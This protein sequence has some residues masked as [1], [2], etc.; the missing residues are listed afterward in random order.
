MNSDKIILS[1]L[2]DNATIAV[3]QWGIPHIRANNKRDLF[4]A[5]GFNAARDRLW[6]I[7][8]WR[9]RG[10]G[11][12]AADFGPGYLEQDR[13]A[14]LFLYRGE[15]ESEW[16]AYCPDAKEIA[17]AF[18]S[19]INAYIEMIN[20]GK[21]AL[22]PE[23]TLFGTSPTRWDAED[24][25]RIRTH[26]MMRN[27]LS[28][29]I[30]ANVISRSS[31]DIDVLRQ[32]LSPPIHPFI[33]DGIA[34]DEIPLEVTDLFKL[35]LAAVTF[36]QDRLNA[37]LEDA[38]SWRTVAGT[39]D[40]VR[41]AFSQGSNNWVVHGS[42][43]ASGRPIL[44]NDP[45]RAH[46]VPSLR[47]LVHLSCPEFDV[48]GAGEPNLPGICIGHNGNSAFGLTLFYGHDQEDLYVYETSPENP[49]Y[50]RYDGG[51]EP[52]RIIEE[53][54]TLKDGTSTVLALRF[55]RHGAVVYEDAARHRAYVIK[56]VWSD[57]GTAPYF[58][59]LASMRTKTFPDFQNAMTQ[60]GVP[61][62][63]QVYADT[64]GTI[65]WVVAGFSPIRSNW[66]GLLPVPGDGR[67]EWK[68][69]FPADRLPTTINP[70]A[71]FFST[72]NENNLP[73]NWN[74]E[75]DQIGYEW[76][77]RSR[78]DRIQEIL[79]ENKLQTIQSSGALQMDSTS[80]VA[81]RLTKIIM[82]LEFPV[83]SVLEAKE[84]FGEWN[85]R[86]DADSSAA[87]LFE[88][89]WSKH[90]RPAL[91]KLLTND[92]VVQD[93]LLPGDP[94]TIVKLLEMPDSRLGENPEAA[95]NDVLARSL[96]AALTECRERLG[97]DRHNWRWGSLHKVH[98]VHATSNIAEDSGNDLSPIEMAGSDSSP[99]NASYRTSDFG[100]TVGASIRVVIDVGEWDKSICIN[101]PGQSGNPRSPHYGDMAAGWAR[102]EFVPLLYS[103]ERVDEATKYRIK[104]VPAS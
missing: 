88:V 7:D 63:N 47:Y 74:H 22:P 14:R 69:Y 54:V 11:L 10:L 73:F 52:M 24:V 104:L 93:L 35:A 40:V 72:A 42:R 41:D 82:S 83:R 20:G 44:A 101:S 43:T 23:F 90:L 2:T 4:F 65:G 64:G 32:A 19:G 85:H 68:G 49:D 71:G 100:V 80:L 8:L 60:W 55:T 46:A 76:L 77:E 58:A 99:M 53:P 36:D 56:T 102:G 78:A 79:S 92:A 18:V 95:R 30:R 50:Y 15:I 1:G 89:W 87:A 28:E 27:A 39:G 9:K 31:A 26:S 45:H 51:W 96:D 97:S 48:I 75:E 16:A 3:D 81:R 6:Q 17:S 70:I 94:E 25:V 59:S 61:A 91:F 103:K 57:P 38:S 29:V 67:F 5:Q 33:A 21:F 37:R 66:D 12:L 98:F 13:A 34:L 62:T 86:L 84:I